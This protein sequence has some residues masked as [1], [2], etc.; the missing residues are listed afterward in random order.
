MTKTPD[1]RAVAEWAAATP[2]GP[3]AVLAALAEAGVVQLD[4][5]GVA[6]WL[7]WAPKTVTEYGTADRAQYEF[8]EADGTVGGHR[9]WWSTTVRTWQAN[10]PGRTGRRPKVVE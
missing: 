5:D 4:R 7:D 8:P 1:L 10:R 9:W 2:R 6:Q 3:S